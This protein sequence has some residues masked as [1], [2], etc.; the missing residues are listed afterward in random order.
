MNA[1][2]SLGL[3]EK[4]QGACRNAP[5]AGRHLVRGKPNFIGDYVVQF[6]LASRNGDADFT[7][8]V[9]SGP[10]SQTSPTMD[11]VSFGDVA[12]RMRK[13]QMGGRL[14]A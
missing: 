1:V 2:A 8:M 13:M 12:H 11:N 10:A 6:Y 5:A 14:W 4:E 7:E 3:L 9:R